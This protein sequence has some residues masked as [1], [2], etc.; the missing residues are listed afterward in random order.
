MALRR[1]RDFVLLQAG[2][3]LSSAGSSLSAV[4][5]PLLVLSLTHSA[6]KAGLVAFARLAPSPLLGLLAGALA[7]R[8]DRR[9][10]MLGADIVRAVAMGTLAAVVVFDPVFWPIPLL[11][12]VEG[13]G[14]AFFDASAPGASRAVVPTQELPAAVSVQQ[15]RLA[16][17]GIGGPPLG[18]ALYGLGRAVP[19]AADAVSYA[20]SFGSLLA[21]R[22]PFQQTREH[23]PL[24]LRAHLVEGLRFLWD[25]PFL[26]TTTFLYAIGNFT[27]PAYLF[28]L[29]VVARRH[30]FTG[31]EIGVLLALFSA[32]VLLGSLVSP[33]ARERLSVRAIVLLELYAGPAVLAFVAWPNV[34]VLA[35][36]LL[37]QA[38]VL[39]I[40]DSVVIGR[41]IAMTPDRLLGRVEA[42]RTT[43]ARAAQPLGPLVAGLLLGTISGRATVAIFAAI[44]IALAVCGTASGALRSPPPLV[45]V[46]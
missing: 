8:R 27:I 41:R 24:R 33:F 45:E 42:A 1:N 26:R 23:R 22:T 39:P 13:A 12:F 19:F 9:R 20:F 18:G 2:Q 37:P 7:D 43:L 25:Q 4:A 30:A 14:D 28:V 35:A 5:Y 17:V 40:T 31:G 16:A 36:A 38:I 46:T 21:M 11:A 34:Y 44:S 3:F 6:P 15:A 10:I 32:F 29:V